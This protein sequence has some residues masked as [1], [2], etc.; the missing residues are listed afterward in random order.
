M[1]WR[2]TAT[3]NIMENEKPPKEIRCLPL[4][5]IDRFGGAMVICAQVL[6]DFK[7]GIEFSADNAISLIDTYSE[8][9]KQLAER[10]MFVFAEIMR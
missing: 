9:D 10:A 6:N 3:N 7:T 1:T 4:T 8:G 2:Q 5:S